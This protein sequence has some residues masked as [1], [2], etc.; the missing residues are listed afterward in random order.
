MGRKTWQWNF[1]SLK[2]PA[3]STT[4]SHQHIIN[5]KIVRTRTEVCLYIHTYTHKH[6][7]SKPLQ[8][9]SAEVGIWFCNYLRNIF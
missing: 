6:N 9:K 2:K 7:K 5:H 3:R 4:E 1:L 8:N